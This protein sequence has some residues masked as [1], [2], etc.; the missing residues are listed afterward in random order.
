MIKTVIPG[1]YTGTISIPSSKS[2]GQRA[3]IAAGLAKGISY[4]QNIGNSND[5]LAALATIQQLGA[6]ITFNTPKNISVKGID[7][8]P[9]EAIL[10]LGESGLS[11]R[12]M[13]CICAAHKGYFKIEG[14]GSALKRPMS[15]FDHYLPKF[16]AQVTSNNHYL[17]L[18]ILAPMQGA[19]VT[20]D[21]SQSSQY[22]SGLMMALPLLETESRI[23]VENLKSKPYLQMTLATLQ[24][25]GVEI[26]QFDY[27]DF[28]IAPQ[29]YLSCSYTIEGDW[30]SA[31]FWLVASALG[32]KIKIQGLKQASLQADKAI[33]K[34]LT[35]ANCTIQFDDGLEIDG[36]N[37]RSFVADLTDCPDLF[38]ALAVFAANT[39]GISTLKGV[40]RLTH[41]ES[42]RG[43][44]LKS[45]FEKLGIHITLEGDE[46]YI[47]GKASIQGGVIDA[48][49]DH[50][51]AMC[52]VILGMI[53]ETPITIEG[54]ESVEKSY[55]DFWHDLTKLNFQATN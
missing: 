35:D 6:E 53:S 42:N 41:K 22:V 11:L 50:R 20:I 24:Q 43:Q 10:N 30:S 7:Q 33:L 9:N 25:F 54:A 55:K 37:R 12:I 4:L 51:I 16:G 36:R 31:S 38:P 40:H 5:E 8:F 29:T 1:K 23:T 14:K 27:T 48:H 52:F 45:E 21:G 2:D 44:V 32:N 26:Q 47:Q 46:M 39:E 18:E 19:S 15:F 3:L 13:T 49:N 17:P 28:V 34:I